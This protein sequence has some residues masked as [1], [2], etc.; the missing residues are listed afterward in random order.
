MEI[1]YGNT[2]VDKNGKTIGEVGQI[3]NDIWSGE[4]RKYV[5]RLE[6]KFSA[7]YFTPDHIAEATGKEV[8]LNVSFDEIDKV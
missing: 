8:R 4:P 1:E 2:V 7:A 6:D 5:V 3:I